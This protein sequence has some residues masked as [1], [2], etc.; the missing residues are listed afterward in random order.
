[1][2]VPPEFFQEESKPGSGGFGAGLGQSFPSARNGR[3]SAPPPSSRL[4]FDD[5]VAQLS[6]YLKARTEF[7]KDSRTTDSYLKTR[8]FRQ[9]G[10]GWCTMKPFDTEGEE[11]Q[12]GGYY[13]E[14]GRQKIKKTKIDLSNSSCKF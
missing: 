7:I 6:D 4:D 2:G 8:S 1:M 9:D 14:L 12:Y 3:S 10:A 5:C 11:D 13:E